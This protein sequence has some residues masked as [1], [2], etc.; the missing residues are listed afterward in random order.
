MKEL[1][2]LMNMQIENQNKQ[3]ERQQK[4]I[5]KLMGKLEINNILRQ[6]TC[7]IKFYS[8]SFRA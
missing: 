2:R 8:L 5:D 6:L 4:Q 7:C 3:I 1:V